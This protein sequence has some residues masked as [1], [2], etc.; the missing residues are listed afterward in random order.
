MEENILNE[1]N[2]T[3]RIELVL[4]DAYDEDEQDEAFCCY[5]GDYIKFPFM[6]KFRGT[7]NSE[8]FK[9]LKFTS[10]TPHRVICESKFC[11][12]LIRTSLSEIEP[13][14]KNS[15]NSTIIEDYLS[16]IGNL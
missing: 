12:K 14:S 16:Y 9:V 5:L 2:R 1:R 4:T 13:I 10:L 11:G 15:D 3:N 8:I 7:K 6:A